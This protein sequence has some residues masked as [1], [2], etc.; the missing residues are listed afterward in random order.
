[1]NHNKTTG[2]S[3]AYCMKDCQSF[4]FDTIKR[5]V[6]VYKNPGPI[7]FAAE[8]QRGSAR[9]S[10]AYVAFP[11]DLKEMFGVGNLV[12]FTATF[13]K[14]VKYQGSLAKM[15]GPQA[16]ILLRKDV[17]AELGKE[18]GDTLEVVIELDDKPR[19]VAV[20][21]DVKKALQTAGQFG[22]FEKLAFTHRKEYIRW[23]EDAKRP[24]TRANRITKTCEM[25]AAGKKM[26]N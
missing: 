3:L 26:S 15:G 9:N 11:Y 18:P 24:E 12:P 20:A 16:M 23:I 17:K 14:R 19:E 4:A 22:L 10:W 21:A 25:L 8:I 13:D 6:R 2:V 1:M 7:A 5:M